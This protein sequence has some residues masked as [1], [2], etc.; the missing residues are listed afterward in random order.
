IAGERTMPILV[1]DA[2][3]DWLLNDY[4]NSAIHKRMLHERILILY[5][6]REYKG[7]KI[8]NI[9]N[10][11]PSSAQITNYIEKLERSGVINP[12]GEKSFFHRESRFYIITAKPPSSTE[13]ALCSIFPYGYI[14]YITAMQWYSITDRLP[15]VVYYTTCS[16]EEWRKRY[17]AETLDRTGLHSYAKDLIPAFPIS[18]KYFGKQV[19]VSTTKNYREPRE[20]ESGIRVQEIG[21]LFTCMLKKPQ[22]CG[23]STHVVDVYMEYGKVFKNKIIKYVD[24]YGGAI[25]KARVGFLL[26]TVMGVKSKTI[27]EWKKEKGNER[28]SSRVLFPGEEFSKVYSPDWNLSINIEELEEYG[29][30]D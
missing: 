7:E 28:G 30:I 27:E 1:A 19:H 8:S 29:T 21:E 24:Q 3:A 5:K 25:D 17:L 20:G 6:E 18:G 10:K 15:K 9:Q 22:W 12:E 2:L 4:P 26:E 23:G 13:E 16:K 14:S 11:F